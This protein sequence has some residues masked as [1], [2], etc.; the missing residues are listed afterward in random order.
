MYERKEITLFVK[1]RIL[2]EGIVKVAPQS[3]LPVFYDQQHDQYFSSN[4]NGNFFSVDVFKRLFLSLNTIHR[5]G[6]IVAAERFY[7]MKDW[8]PRRN[9]QHR[10]HTSI[11]DAKLCR[12]VMLENA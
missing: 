9:E 2:C 3:N 5:Y 10:M 12:E 6:S 7:E 1:N 8:R 4:P 11:Q